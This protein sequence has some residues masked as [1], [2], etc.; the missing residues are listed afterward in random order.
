MHLTTGNG[1]GGPSG[2]LGSKGILGG[3]L[4]V[5]LS[6]TLCPPS[7]EQ[8]SFHLSMRCRATV[9]LQE[10]ATQIVVLEVGR[11]DPSL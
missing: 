7:H 2:E 5:S 4:S 8:A 11:G 6:P 3:A 9:L 10:P 1:M